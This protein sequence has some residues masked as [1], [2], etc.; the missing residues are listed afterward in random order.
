VEDDKDRNTITHSWGTCKFVLEEI[1]PQ[2][3]EC[4]YLLLKMIE[5][6]IRDYVNLGHSLI[7]VEKQ[8][9]ETAKGFLFDDSYLIEYGEF[10]VGL[11]DILD[12]LGIEIEWFRERISNLRS[13][14]TPIPELVGKKGAFFNK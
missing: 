12:V 6:A 10:E 8:H 2:E 14:R 13:S 5:Q 11:S 1:R 4:R 3:D 7:P 9:H